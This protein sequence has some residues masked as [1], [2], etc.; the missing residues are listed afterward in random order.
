M[1]RSQEHALI[2]LFLMP[3]SVAICGG[4]LVG[5][6]YV[7]GPSLRRTLLFSL[8]AVW[9]GL[10]W[11]WILLQQKMRR[12]KKVTF[13]ER[14]EIIHKK[15]ALAGYVGVWLYFV[16]A[17]VVPWWIVGPRGTVSAN[18]LPIILIGGIIAFSIVQSLA[19]LI[20]YGWSGKNSEKLDQDGI[21]EP[22]Y[23]K[24]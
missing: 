2:W 9:T 13:D 7:E 24:G 6:V 8:F 19:V 17:C 22:H 21:L 10:F 20:Q 5:L 16:T 18:I 1:N 14:D 23:S 12:K 11:L 15:A 4:L 3:L